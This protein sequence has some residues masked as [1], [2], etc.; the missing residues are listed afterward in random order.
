[1]KG[2]SF[3]ANIK[4]T[5]PYAAPLPETKMMCKVF[6]INTWIGDYGTSCHIMNNN[7]EMFDVK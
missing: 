6:T 1:M 3:T 7:T 5:T 4:F 2:V